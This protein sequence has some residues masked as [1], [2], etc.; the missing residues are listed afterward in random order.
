MI[1]TT[2]IQIIASIFTIFALSRVY[3]RFKE[4]KLSSIAFFLWFFVWVAGMVAVFFPDLT[5]K[6]SRI[7]GIGRGAD[8]VLYA[9]IAVIFYL[10]FRIYIKIEDTQRQIT[11]VARKVALQKFLKKRKKKISSGV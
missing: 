11:E 10:L 9:S 1:P 5:T 2:A 8:A 3:L 7:F 6:V 4:R